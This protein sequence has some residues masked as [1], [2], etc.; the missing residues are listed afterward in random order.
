MY[1]HAWLMFLGLF[2]A[3]VLEVLVTFSTPF[4]RAIYFLET[5]ASGGTKFGVWGY[6]DTISNGTV[7]TPESLGYTFG[8]E[9]ANSTLI[10]VLVLF[11]I[12]AGFCILCLVALFPL[13]CVPRLKYY[14]HPVFC[15]LCMGAALSAVGAFVVSIVIF[16]T[17]MSQFQAA[18]YSASFG[19]ALWMSLAAA[20]V[21]SLVGLNAGCGTCLGG[22]FGRGSS[23]YAYNY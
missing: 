4:I 2:A 7:C 19:P 11:P 1:Y 13:L 8:T 3:F 16:T 21:L 17:S 10:E 6:C 15:I 12:C 5:S 20:V 22:R 18:G 23:Q 14:P 9:I